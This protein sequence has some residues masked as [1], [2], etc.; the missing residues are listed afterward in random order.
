MRLPLA[1]LTLLAVLA[2]TALGESAER[3]AVRVVPRFAAP[4]PGA[5]RVTAVV[6]RDAR[7]RRLVI[8]V[9]SARLYRSSERPLHGAKEP[10]RHAFT[11]SHLPPGQYEIRVHLLGTDGEQTEVRLFS[12]RSEDSQ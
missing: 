7:N 10:R 5:M 11:F 2:G 9:E 8:E 3:L 1:A 6:E 4:S 12:V